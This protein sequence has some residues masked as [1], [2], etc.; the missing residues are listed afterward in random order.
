MISELDNLNEAEIAKIGSLVKILDKSGFDFLTLEVGAFR[1]TVGTGKAAPTTAIP[2]APVR[3]ETRAPAGQPAATAAEP[4]ATAAAS[5][6][7][8]ARNGAAEEGLLEITATTMGTFYSRPSPDAEPFVAVG[9]RIDPE[10]TVGLIEVMK[11]FN[12]VAAGVTG[13][14]EQICVEDAQLVEYGQVLVRVR[15]DA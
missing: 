6:P 8:T 2:P 12:G 11:L 15:P 13:T 4:A 5:A 1:L 10:T 7:S 14:V 9:S 3:E